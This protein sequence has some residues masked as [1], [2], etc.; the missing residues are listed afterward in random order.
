MPERKLTDEEVIK[1]LE[2][3]S[4]GTGKAI[5]QATLDLITRQ[6]AEIERL[7]VSFVDRI[8]VEFETMFNRV[9]SK[10]EEKSGDR[11][12]MKPMYLMQVESEIF[13]IMGE[14]RKKCM[15]DKQ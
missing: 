14:L 3:C 11:V 4:D 5:I 2:C 6:K 1:A 8:L 12:Y 9:F 13:T 7:R 10:Y 15:E